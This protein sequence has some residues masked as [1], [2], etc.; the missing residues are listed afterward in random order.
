MSLWYYCLERRGKIINST[1]RNN[2][3]LQNTI[4]H[5]RL[6]G[7][8]TDISMLCEYGW[9]DWV[10]YCIEGPNF[11]MSKKKLGRVLGPATNAGSVLAQWIPT[12]A[13]KVMPIQTLRHSTQAALNYPTIKQRMQE[14]TESIT[15]RLGDSGKRVQPSKELEGYPAHDPDFYQEYQSH[16]D[17]ELSP[18]PI[19]EMDDIVLDP[20]ALINAEVILPH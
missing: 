18:G 14:Y 10:V 15:K 11:P 4:P 5:T 8:P 19:P 12:K 2:P 7:Q 17:D 6:S 9:Y 1:V 13:S 3:Q 20:A 16:Y